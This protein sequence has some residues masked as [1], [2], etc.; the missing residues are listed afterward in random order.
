MSERSESRATA[1]RLLEEV[2]AI[3]KDVRLGLDFSGRGVNTS[4]ALLA[5]QGLVAYLEGNKLAAA[6][7]LATAA[8]EIRARLD[9]TLR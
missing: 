7:D 2:E 1:I 6:D 9:A 4:L 8:D 5:L 3:L